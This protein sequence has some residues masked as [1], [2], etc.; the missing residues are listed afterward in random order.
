MA[1]YF[2]QDDDTLDTNFMEAFLRSPR[3]RKYVDKG[4]VALEEV[5]EAKM[6][7]R[8]TENQYE[9]LEKGLGVLPA[10]TEVINV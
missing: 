2:L 10:F 5:L 1:N 8:P 9:L 4:K 7:G 6:G 3:I